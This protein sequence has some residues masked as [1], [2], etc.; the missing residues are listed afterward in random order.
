[1][2]T[3]LDLVNNLEL[4]S[5]TDWNDVSQVFDLSGRYNLVTDF[6]N[7]MNPTGST[8]LDTTVYRKLYL[9]QEE[10]VAQ[11]AS[12]VVG[13]S[14]VTVTLL[15]QGTPTPAPVTFFRPGE[16]VLTGTMNIQGKIIA[17]PSAGVIEIEPIGLG[18]TGGI[19][20]SQL[21]SAL[22][23]NSFVSG[24]GYIGPDKWTSGV[25]GLNYIPDVFLNYL[26]VKREGHKWAATDGVKTRPKFMD[27]NWSDSGV[28]MACQRMLK[29]IERSTINGIQTRYNSALGGN[30]DCNGGIDWS[31]RNRG[32]AVVDL[33]A[34]PTESQFTNWLIDVHDR[35]ANAEPKT[36]MMGRRMYQYITNNFP[37]GYVKQMEISK[38][39]A[40]GVNLNYNMYSVGGMEVNLMT[41]VPV[42]QDPEFDPTPTAASGLQGRKREWYAYCIDSSPVPV[43]GGGMRPA[44]EK[45]HFGESPFYAVFNPGIRNFAVG[46]SSAQDLN[47]AGGVQSI[48]YNAIDGNSFDILYHGGIDMVGKFSG[49]MTMSV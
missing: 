19:T 9:G 10:R 15:P 47:V 46:A 4:K 27:G 42:L 25:D 22:S 16:H 44:I 17:V 28:R 14:S 8:S 48:S 30:Q 18:A 37:T 3:S 41:N 45:I 23:V 26:S 6:I 39:E 12:I 21:A 1:M 38:G 34:A 49:M 2:I 43:I 32:G 29:D 35:K 20:V 11:V 31:I 7:K 40:N 13:A 36:V 24:M 33:T 5:L